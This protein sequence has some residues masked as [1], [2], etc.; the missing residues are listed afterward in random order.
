MKVTFRTSVSKGVTRYDR[1]HTYD[2]PNEEAK[3]WIKDSTA[4]PAAEE[5]EQARVAS[6]E[7]AAAPRGQPRRR[8]GG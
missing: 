8:S 5:P 4:V 2:L 3:A 6:P 7:R 1:G